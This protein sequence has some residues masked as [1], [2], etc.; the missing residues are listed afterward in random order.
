MSALVLLLAALA[1]A[2]S[3][4]PVAP[5]EALQTPPPAA[6]TATAV[7]ASTAAAEV[8]VSTGGVKVAGAAPK[9]KL[10]RPIHATLHPESKD[11]EPLSLKPGGDP[12]AV[13][14]K[15]VLRQEKVKGKLKGAASK[16]KA[17]ARVHKA[18]DARWLVVSVWPKSLERRRLHLEVRFRIVEGFVEDAKALAVSV[19]DRGYTGA[20]LDSDELRERGVEF[21]EESPEKGA[22]VV[23]ALDPRP[24]KTARNSGTL[25]M[26]AFGDKDI[27][28][29]D[30]SWAVVGLK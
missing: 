1:S 29:V 6:S 30:A 28:L 20:G 19:V 2:Q 25:K 10:T 16:A 26:A 15:V 21:E 11:W 4:M 7:A 12:E 22:I 8:A 3:P 14:T 17:T 13:E 23:S 5:Q 27:G 9:A 24:S 18:G